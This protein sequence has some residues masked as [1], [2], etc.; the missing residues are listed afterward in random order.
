[1]IALIKQLFAPK[2]KSIRNKVL[3]TLFAITIFLIGNTI[4][5]PGTNPANLN[6]SGGSLDILNLISGGGLKR[7]SIFALG[8]SP[9]ITAS[10]VIQLLSMDVIPYLSELKELG[11]VGR[12]KSNQITRYLGILLAFVQGYSYALLFEK[13][14]T[15]LDNPD[16]MTYTLVALILTAGTAGV[17]WLGDQITHRGV[18]NGISVIIMTGIVSGLPTMFS[19]TFDATVKFG[20]VRE[21]FISSLKFGG[22][23]LAYVLLILLIIFIQEAVRRIA[24]QYSNRTSSA[25]GGAGRNFIPLKVNSAGVIPVIFAG[26]ILTAPI[27]IAQLL[28]QTSLDTTSAVDWMNKYLNYQEPIG[29]GI[30]IALVFA[31]SYFYTFIQINPNDTAE[32][33]QKSGAYIPGVRPGTET[34]SYISKVLVRLTFIGGIFIAFIAGLPIAIKFIP[35]LDLP[36]AYAIGG[37]GMLIVVGVALEMMRSLEE[38]LIGRDY[39]GYIK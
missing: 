30:Y 8:V 6:N 15:I 38:Q 1:M 4:P 36:S 35:G 32:N 25:Y 12:K 11:E 39:E 37:T 33:L 22:L 10:I 24:L 9:Y 3:F 31:F 27:I 5:V 29:F 21:T 13:Q 16:A 23:V 26:S 17:L 7:F 20:D 18:G 34:A 19:Q 2:N 14:Y 28:N